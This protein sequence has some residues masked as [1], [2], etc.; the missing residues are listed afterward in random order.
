MARGNSA[1]ATANR[2]KVLWLIRDI[3]NP[4]REDPYFPRHRHMDFFVG[5]SWAS[6]LFA[7]QDGRNQESTSEAVNAWHA[8]YL[9]GEAIGDVRLS[10]LGRLMRRV[11]TVSAQTY[12]QIKTSS[13]AYQS[14]YKERSVVGIL[15]S[16]KV[17][18]ATFFGETPAFVYGIQM[19]P[20][21]A[22]SEALLDPTWLSDAWPAIAPEVDTGAWGNILTLGQAVIDPETAMSRA[23]GS[24]TVDDGNSRANTLY[25]IAT[26]P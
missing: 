24:S 14:P 23:L 21:T 18:F 22:A 8:L 25:W 1:W 4:S 17:E 2:D 26:R 11:E 16:Q 9:F 13:T 6:G 10:Q 19:L 15:W 5:H 7:F 12:W 20:F 3:A